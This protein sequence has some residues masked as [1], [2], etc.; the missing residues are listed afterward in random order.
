MAVAIL[1]A[2]VASMELAKD[3]EVLKLMDHELAQGFLKVHQG[4]K[5]LHAKLHHKKAQK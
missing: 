4:L 5:S 2:V 1:A 3:S